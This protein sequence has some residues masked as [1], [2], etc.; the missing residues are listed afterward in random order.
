[1]DRTEQEKYPVPVPLPRCAMADMTYEIASARSGFIPVELQKLGFP[2]LKY[3]GFYIDGRRS[4]PVSCVQQ[5]ALS[6]PPA[7]ARATGA[8]AVISPGPLRIGGTDREGAAD[9]ERPPSRAAL[10]VCR[11][12]TTSGSELCAAV[13]ARRRGPTRPYAISRPIVW[14][15]T[16]AARPPPPPML[17]NSRCTSNPALRRPALTPHPSGLPTGQHRAV[18]APTGGVRAVTFSFL[19]NYSRNTGL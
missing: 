13:A 6:P 5:K 8:T 9:R 12:K 18:S 10:S 15:T 17:V 14:Q 11:S 19:C 3:I 16:P 1:M 2:N 4:K 7:A